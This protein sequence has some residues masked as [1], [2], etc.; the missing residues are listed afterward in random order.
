MSRKNL[1]GTDFAQLPTIGGVALGYLDIPQV[2]QNA[3]ATFALTDRGKHW[4]KTNTTAYTWTIP[5]NSSVAFPLGTALLLI[6]DSGT[7]AVT[8]ARTSGVALLNGATDANYTLAVN[9]A[10]TI[11][12]VGTDRWRVL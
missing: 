7:G 3:N 8:I 11:V 4:I 9:S 1:S 5:L 12:K 6:N 2:I 10:V